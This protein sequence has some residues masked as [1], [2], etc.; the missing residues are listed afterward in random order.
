[1]KTT[2]IQVKSPAT[3]ANLGPGFDCLG[4]ALDIW[5]FVYM[6]VCDRPVISISGEGEDELPKDE[7]NLVYRSAMRLL[8]ELGEEGVNLN[9]KCHNN[10]PLKRGLGSSSA[11]I[12][13]G[14][15]G[16][17]YL[18]GNRM[19]QEELLSLVTSLEGHPDNVAPALLGGIQ[20]AIDSTHGITASPIPVPKDLAVVLYIPEFS[21]DTTLAR[22][23][24]SETV[25]RIDAVYNVNRVALLV[26]ALAT[27]RLQDLKVGTEDRLHQP[28]R[29]S[30]FPAME[31]IIQAAINGGALGAFLSGSGSTILALTKGR[32]MT[33]G[34]EMAEAARKANVPGIIK[35]TSPTNH[36]TKAKQKVSGEN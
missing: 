18:V 36:G 24:L 16:A 3:T 27:S 22:S 10:I 20:I 13:A 8:K 31:V 19:N 26:N 35:I 5:N 25:P 21:I 12:V 4:M 1:M 32:E 9:V 7:N 33:V 28:K 34:Y 6:Q 2:K 14:M 15:V 11:A 30:L 17:N 29:Q 23:V